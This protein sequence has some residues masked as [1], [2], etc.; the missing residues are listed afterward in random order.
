M[1]PRIKESVRPVQSDSRYGEVRVFHHPF[2]RTLD[3]TTYAA[4]TQT[5][6]GRRTAE[7][8]DTLERMISI[9]F[10]NAVVKKEDAVLDFH[11]PSEVSPTAVR[12]QAPL[13]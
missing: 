5:Y 10:G 13:T 12:G 7:E 11:A 1:Q 4:V 3:G 2:E 9:E 8:Y 6:G